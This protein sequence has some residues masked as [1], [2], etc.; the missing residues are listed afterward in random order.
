MSDDQNRQRAYPKS[1]A[2]IAG[3]ILVPLA[4]AAVVIG[5][6]GYA[7]QTLII[8]TN[9][10]AAGRG[11]VL[12]R[13]D[14][15]VETGLADPVAIAIGPDDSLYVAGG[16][17][18]LV[19]DRGTDKPRKTLSLTRL[20]QPI[21]A[22][23]VGPDGELVLG[24]YDH[25]ELMKHDRAS[26]EAF[27]GLGPRACITSVSVNGQWIWAADAGNRQI[28]RYDKTG[29]ATLTIGGKPRAG[30]KP[31]FI[32][33][34]PYMDVA[35]TADGG[36]WVANTGKHRLEMRGPDGNVVR[37][38]G[39]FG[40]SPAGFCGCCNPSEFA[41]LPDGGFVTAEKGIPR[42]KIYSQNGNFQGF[43][44]KPK[45]L[46]KTAVGLDVATD[47]KGDIYVLVPQS[48]DVMVYTKK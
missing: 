31:I 9:D 44:I 27:Y 19:Y 38:W 1:A 48:G 40:S 47:S 6:I 14:H 12:Y 10:D 11:P 43:V 4:V 42:V 15:T 33:P 23:T 18:I 45:D 5:W 29:E 22:L 26:R 8:Q 13:L 36:V 30:E 41:I 35:A 46:P 34:S 24:L 28:V 2:W 20:Y 32:I 39:T 17:Q 21:T 16:D 7:P 25:V 3:V 37:S